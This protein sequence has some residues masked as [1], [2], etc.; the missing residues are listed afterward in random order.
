MTIF[1]TLLLCAANCYVL[2]WFSEWIVYLNFLWHFK[3]QMGHYQESLKLTLKQWVL[4]TCIFIKSHKFWILLVLTN[5][6]WHKPMKE[7]PETFVFSSYLIILL[8][9]CV[10]VVYFQ[11][12]AEFC[13]ETRLLI[14]NLCPCDSFLTFGLPI[15]FIYLY[16]YFVLKSHDAILWLPLVF[17]C[18]SEWQPR[19]IDLPNDWIDLLFLLW[20]TIINF[21][22]NCDFDLLVPWT[23]WLLSHRYSWTVIPALRKNITLLLHGHLTEL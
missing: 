21:N 16:F 3:T 5:I 17:L 20:L 9:H 12:F 10:A 15:H 19:W 2:E 8:F 18:H 22:L 6:P 23:H 4:G 13:W 7:F 11:N 14:F 1:I